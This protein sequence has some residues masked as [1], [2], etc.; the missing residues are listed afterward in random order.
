MNPYPAFKGLMNIDRGYL[1]FLTPKA[2]L[3]IGYKAT[4]SPETR[5]HC[6]KHTK[7]QQG[8]IS[9]TIVRNILLSLDN[10]GEGMPTAYQYK[11]A[12]Q[13]VKGRTS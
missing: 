12:P 3:T 2:D 4:T 5:G 1:I 6:E 11:F 7:W 13:L 10:S 8:K 9:R